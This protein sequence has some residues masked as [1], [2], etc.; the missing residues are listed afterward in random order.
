VVNLFPNLDSTEALTAEAVAWLRDVL[1]ADEETFVGFSGGKDSVVAAEL[2]RMS[3]RPHRL[4]YSFTGLDAPPVVRFIRENYPDCVFLRPSRT[5]WENLAVNVPPSDRLRWCCTSLK[6]EP[7]WKM[8]HRF[9]V[10][11][12]RAEESASRAGRGRTNHFRTAQ[13]DHF[14]F[15]P[16]FRW[17]E[18]HVW[19][20]IAA[21]DLPY[22]P[23]YD[24]GF[25]RVGCVVCPYHSAP[26]GKMHQLYRDRW[27][28]FFRVWEKEIG[29][30]WRK[31]KA[32]GRNMNHDSPQAFLEEWY[33]NKA[34]RWYA[35][36]PGEKNK[37]NQL[38]LFE[39][40]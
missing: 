26:S 20:F 37:P 10:M 9:R 5:F 2:V 18:F 33:K 25:D 40:A 4:F 12:L 11:G 1:P 30:L 29:K 31:R 34:A 21:N 15:Y 17:K 32:A 23:L 24:W 3:G 8:P 6:K 14:Q 38:S 7:A 39:R 16:I 27:P 13:T 22:A 28:G 36:E 19:E 35:V